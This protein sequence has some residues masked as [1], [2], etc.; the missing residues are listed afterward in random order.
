MQ[1]EIH[2]LPSVENPLGKLGNS[3]VFFV[4]KLDANSAFW[5]R[6][7]SESSQ[8][9]TTFINPWGRYCFSRLPYGITTGSEQFQRCM[10]G[11][12]TGLEGVECNIDDI[13][14]TY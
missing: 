6:T 9:L 11:K 14:M 7:L 1:R 8:L 5:Q 12:L 10:A 2:P 4:S 13:M 3:K